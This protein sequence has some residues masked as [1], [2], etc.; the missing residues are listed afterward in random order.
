MQAGGNQLGESGQQVRAHKTVAAGYQQCLAFQVCHWDC[1]VSTIVSG[2]GKSANLPTPLGSRGPGAGASS[3]LESA[4][5]LVAQPRQVGLVHFRNHFLE[6]GGRL[7]AEL[8]AGLGWV[9]EQYLD[10][11]RAEER[12]IYDQM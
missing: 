1:Q 7:P 2:V 10:F 5:D 9:A 8:P 11:R 12:R 4:I 6:A 3:G